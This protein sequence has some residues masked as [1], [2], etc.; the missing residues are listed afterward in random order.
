MTAQLEDLRRV[1]LE[2]FPQVEVDP[3]VKWGIGFRVPR[4]SLLEV[5]RALRDMPGVTCDYLS[6]ITGVDLRDRLQVVYHLI[7]VSSGAK[8]VLKVDL[9]PDDPEV[10]SVTPVW[11]GA[12]WHEREAWDLLG[13][14]FRNHPNLKR[15]LLWEG[16]EGHPLRKDFVDR[17]PQRER[18]VR[19]R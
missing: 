2:Q 9:P 4:E 3:D 5:A 16:Y 1:V 8:V 12:D 11:P 6:N 19:Q 15:I 13:I 17:R 14:R 18:K 10:D 7:G